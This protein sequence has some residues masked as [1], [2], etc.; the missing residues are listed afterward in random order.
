MMNLVWPFIGA[1]M[2]ERMVLTTTEELGEVLLPDQQP[3]YLGGPIP[4]APEEVLARVKASYRP[5]VT[6]E[7]LAALTAEASAAAS[8]DEV[9]GPSPSFQAST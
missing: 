1:K 7:Q 5:W 9:P 4:S 2:R 3:E 8:A 6:E